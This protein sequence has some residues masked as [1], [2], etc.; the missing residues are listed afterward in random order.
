MS[1]IKCRWI[2]YLQQEVCYD[3]STLF[4]FLPLQTKTSTSNSGID[5]DLI[6][7]HEDLAP[8]AALAAGMKI[9]SCL[10]TR[11]HPPISSRCFFKIS[12]SSPS[13]WDWEWHYIIVL[14]TKVF[15]Q[16]FSTWDGCQFWNGQLFCQ[17]L[18]GLCSN[19]RISCGKHKNV[20]HI[21]FWIMSVMMLN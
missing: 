21:S 1:K 5:K 10:H 9:F 18:C 12:S 6:F 8:A 17:P 13:V 4:F 3:I 11:W 2:R 20:W 19:Q 14:E 7:R 15:Q 16:F